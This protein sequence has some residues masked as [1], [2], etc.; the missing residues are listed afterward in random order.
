MK[1]IACPGFF[2]GGEY[3]V[4]A[5]IRFGSIGR[6]T[7]SVTSSTLARVALKEVLWP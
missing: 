4:M 3:F 7:V 1:P 6:K 5:F 2:L